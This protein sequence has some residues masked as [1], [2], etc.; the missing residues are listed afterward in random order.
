MP[1]STHFWRRFRGSGHVRETKG[2]AGIELPEKKIE[3]I[4]V[5]NESE[6]QTLYDQIRFQMRAEVV[7]DNRIV[8]DD[9]DEIL[10]RLLRLVQVASNPHLV[11]RSYVK[12]PGK[13]PALLR[14]VAT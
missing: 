3:N 8:E 7:R 12:V 14:I 2:S 10:K 13:L 11:D 4:R 9:A 6:Q 5:E 1:D